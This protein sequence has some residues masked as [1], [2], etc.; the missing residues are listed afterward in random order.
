MSP[1]S[2]VVTGPIIIDQSNV[3]E[4]IKFVKSVVGEEAYK[5]Q[6]TW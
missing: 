3:D 6:L 1:I 2:D 4:W 5:K